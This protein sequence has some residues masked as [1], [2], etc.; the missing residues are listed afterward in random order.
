MRA[1]VRA[2]VRACERACVRRCRDDAREG[3]GAPMLPFLCPSL[4]T[5]TTLAPPPSP[6]SAALRT[7][8]HSSAV[9]AKWP[10]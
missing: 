6:F 1:C 9:S 4:E 3:Q 10:R 7:L 2:C 5:T 8:G